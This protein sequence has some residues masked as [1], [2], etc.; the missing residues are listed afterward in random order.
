MRVVRVL[1]T[2]GLLCLS[3]F[4]CGG[5][6]SVNQSSTPPCETRVPAEHPA[7][8]VTVVVF[9]KID[10]T[11]APVPQNREERFV[12]SHLYETL[13]NIDCYGDVQPALAK[14]WKEG[15][16]GWLIELRDG[17]Q[18]W[19]QSP[20]TSDDVVR[21]FD[22]AIKRGLAITSVDIIDRRTFLVKGVRGAPDI[23]LLAL[24]MIAIRRDSD[25]G[26]PM[27]T[28][29]WQFNSDI[30][31]A[32]SV[33]IEPVVTALGPVVRFVQAN[34]T[35]AK[36]LVAGAADAMITDDPAAID[37]ARERHTTM[38]PLAWDRAY[39]LVAPMR[40]S[41]AELPQR[42]CDALARDAVRIDSRGGSN[43]LNA[44]Q[45]AC[46]MS[47]SD[48]EALGSFSKSQLFF[49]SDDTTARSLAERIVALAAMD[50][51]SSE[52]ARAIRAAVPGFGP[53]LRAI[54]LKRP[55]ASERAPFPQLAVANYVR[56][57]SWYRD[58]PCLGSS[59]MRDMAWL[60]SL[61]PLSIA[62][63][64]LVETRAHFIAMSDRISFTVDAS[65][66][67]YLVIAGRETKS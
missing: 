22:P 5:R 38:A 27:G 17:A 10:P 65:G 46:A 34:P 59:F 15:S 43:I 4:G 16:D 56:S 32:E 49:D 11:H 60:A 12:F 19:D 3:A 42:V 61:R 58:F 55:A 53:S 36:D 2:A 64:P 29:A 54:A 66:H 21:S 23:K 9:D 40:G 47:D 1:G 35:D 8:T 37:Y 28:G 45:S 63:L 41:A 13:V 51:A 52:E 33:V 62:V 20:V 30:P 26:P 25:S 44:S 50:T 39:V 67:V 57:L 48:M 18:F 14:S 6:S 31:V 24:P 7:D